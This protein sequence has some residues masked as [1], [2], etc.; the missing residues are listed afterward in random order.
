MEKVEVNG[1]NTHPVYQWLRLHSSKDAAP[2]SWNFCL[3]MVGSDGVTV[4]RYA[5]SRSPCT[6]RADIEDALAA[7]SKS[8]VAE[9][10]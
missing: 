6:L 7:T 4:T 1:S 8:A 2:L 10:L 3:F 9:L 5:Q